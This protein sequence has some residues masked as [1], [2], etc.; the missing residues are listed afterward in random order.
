MALPVFVCVTT[1]S[2]AQEEP[3]LEN[4]HLKIQIQ[5]RGL[6]SVTDKHACVPNR[7]GED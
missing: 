5:S 1:Q 3:G 2:I 4:D 7:V 6:F